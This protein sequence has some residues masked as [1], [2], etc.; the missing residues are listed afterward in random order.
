MILGSH[1]TMSYLPPKKWYMYPF[2]FMAKCQNRP[3]EDQYA[4]GARVFDIR[5]SFDKKGNIEFRHGL[6]AYKTE[7]PFEVFEY[8]NSVLEPIKIRVMLE[9]TKHSKRQ[10]QQS[11]LFFMLCSYL[12]NTYTNIEFFGGQR[13]YDGKVIYSFKNPDIPLTQMISSMTWKIWDDWW[14]WLYAHFMNKKNLEKYKNT[15][16]TV[17]MDFI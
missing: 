11:A 12:E 5:I 3:I 13:K 14:P 1:N 17:L 10:E 2:R 4:A 8:F 15:D 9:N 6:S 7:N 16:K